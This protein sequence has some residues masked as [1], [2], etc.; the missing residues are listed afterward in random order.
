MNIE[1]DLTPIYKLAA[2]FDAMTIR[3]RVL[4]STAALGAILV[5]WY[6][7]LMQPLT[8][9]QQALQSELETITTNI[10]NTATAMEQ[11]MEPRNT[12]MSQ[13]KSAQSEL[14]DVDHQLSTTIAGM[15]APEHMA[16]VIQDVLH[17]QH[18]LTLISL[19]NQPVMPLITTPDI[20]PEAPANPAPESDGSTTPNPVA[21]IPAPVIKTGPYVHPL[22]V[23]VE[24]SYADIIAYL[25]ALETMKWHV[26]W[27]RLELQ[28]KQYPV[29]RV[30]LEMSTLSL[31]DTWMGV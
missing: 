30:Q 7:L 26:Y 20:P 15:I 13:L 22:E 10:T 9:K 21:N 17:Q 23:V 24:G 5:I 4:I 25:K 8:A 14:G 2:R 19:R 1:I 27:I 16:A 3:E 18:G 31:D 11:A 28:T 6:T 12:A 29:N